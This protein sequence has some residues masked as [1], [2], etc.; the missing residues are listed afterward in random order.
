MAFSFF[1]LP[2]QEKL[3]FK[4]NDVYKPVRYGTSLKDGLDKVQFWR[5]FL[6]HYAHPLDAW[7]D[8]WPENPP[9]YRSLLNPYTYNVVFITSSLK[10]SHIYVIKIVLILVEVI[11]FIM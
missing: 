9:H 6:K 2:T 8:S 7:I 3:K 10:L 5:V 1:N 4:S 11:F